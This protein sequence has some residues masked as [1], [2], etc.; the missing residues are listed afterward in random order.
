[1]GTALSGKNGTV[2]IGSTA[3]ALVSKWEL[4]KEVVTSRF[5][6][7]ESSGTKKTL[8]GVYHASGS[9]SG[10]LDTA[11]AST[12]LEGVSATL[13]LY[14]NATKY[15]TVPSVIKSFK[16]GEVDIDDGKVIPFTA[17][18]ESDGVCTEPTWS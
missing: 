1:M 13:L 17:Q 7:N 14:V 3:V 6:N 2:K 15:Y 11:A 18:F 12:I 5:A 4:T 9:I 10:Q 8:A 16:V